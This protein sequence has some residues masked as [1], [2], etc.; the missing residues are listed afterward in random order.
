MQLAARYAPFLPKISIMQKFGLSLFFLLAP[1]LCFTQNNLQL[2]GHLPYDT[3]S[4][5]GCWHYVDSTGG[6]WALVGTSKGVSIVDLNDPAQPAQRFAVPGLA[7]NWRELKTWAGF[8]YV[9]SEAVGSGITIVDLRELPD[10]IVWKTW[11]G[12]GEY[13]GQLQRSHALAA[14]DGYL[15]VFGGNTPTDGALIA[16]LADPWN[17]TTVSLYTDRYVHD[18]YIRGDTLWASEIYEG[19]FTAIDVSDKTAPVALTSTPTPGAFNHNSW[20][21]DDSRTLFTTDEKTNAPLASF[22]VSDLNNITMLDTYYPSQNPSR[23]VHNVRVLND[24]LIN[25]SYGGQL[26]LV[27]AARPDNLIETA[28]ASLGTSLVWDADPYLPSGIVFATAKNEG[29]FIYQ[30]TYQHA[31]WLEGQVTDAVTGLPVNEAKVFVLNTVNAD[32]SRPDGMYK[33]GNAQP[34]LYTVLAEKPGYLPATIENVSLQAGIVTTLNIALTPLIIATDDP[35]GAES[36]RVYPT[37]FHDAVTVEIPAGSPFLTGGSVAQVFDL[38]GKMVLET[39]LDGEK[40][41]LRFEADLPAGSYTLRL[42]NGALAN[43]AVQIVQ[44]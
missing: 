36:V 16:D 14:T 44:E 37:L 29:L 34:G 28:W 24:F 42:K 27:D 38:Q 17:P 33:T 4:L 19:Q 6:E 39:P 43:K 18:G 12:D 32:T 7:S 15:Y 35:A 26:T 23:E 2:L 22:D 40:T 13:E 41:V 5:A 30:P 21:S 25:P 8:A 31:C 1:F 3:A 11:F 9:G 10:T 20:L